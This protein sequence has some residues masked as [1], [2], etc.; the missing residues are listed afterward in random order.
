MQYLYP[1]IGGERAVAAPSLQTV[2]IT[3]HLKL[4]EVNIGMAEQPKLAKIGDYWD[5]DT[6]S[7]VAELLT[8]YQDLF[9]TKFSELKGITGDLGVMR[10][11][12]KPDA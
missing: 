7:K 11:T 5:D 1:R 10:I 4:R 2:D 8:E 9:P 3:K 12:L 6:V